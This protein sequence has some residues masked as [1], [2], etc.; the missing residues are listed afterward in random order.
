MFWNRSKRQARKVDKR[1]AP[2]LLT[3]VGSDSIFGSSQAGEGAWI[4]VVQKM[5]EVYAE[6]VDMQVEVEQKNGELEEA[7][8]FIDSVLS[9]MTDVLI[10]CDR[11]GNIQQVNAALV[12]YAGQ[13]E[14]ALIGQP[15]TC[16]FALEGEPLNARLAE[17]IKNDTT[18]SDCEVS[19]CGVNGGPIPLSVN[20]SPRH[21]IRGHTRGMVVIGRP[22]GEL[23]R[24][25]RELDK[26]HV[27]LRQAQQ[28]LIFSEKMAALGRLVAGVAH[29]LNNPISFVY[30]NMHA[31]KKYGEK[32]THYFKA[33][34]G[35]T[36]PV[37][38][39]QLRETLKIDKIVDD[40]SPLVEGTLEGAERVSDIV[41][42]LRRF[43]ATQKEPEEAFDLLKMVETATGWVL[44]GARVKP[45]IVIECPADL[46]IR[47]RKGHIHQILVNLA[48]NAVDILAG[49][50][51]PRLT[52]HCRVEESGIFIAV[53]DNGAGICEQDIPHIFEPFY[54]TKPIG[55]GTGLG[56]YV[57][58]SLAEELG[59]SLKGGNHPDGGA[60]FTLKLPLSVM[61]DRGT[62]PAGDHG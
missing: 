1:T 9:S 3:K 16:L 35:D 32:I 48:Q 4:E 49:R 29:E 36:D 50:S 15:L 33:T 62:N 30:G 23:Q 43:S 60:V 42:E 59:A 21:D 2:G 41:Q 8:I 7:Q 40:M 38:L 24:A 55:Q 14:E 22:V 56:L 52:I 5:D 54:T 25:Y 27:S 13:S 46:T 53:H 10:V 31:L 17:H 26:A 58:Y 57:S 19:L 6:L 12:K 39:A 28:Q 44:R 37:A 51:E 18:V 61:N 20:C 34:E 47:T 11:N 45:K